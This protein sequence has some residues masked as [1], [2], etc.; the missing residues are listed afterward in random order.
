MNINK[1]Y[2]EN[3]QLNVDVRHLQQENHRF[4]KI[5]RNKQRVIDRQRDYINEILY[6]VRNALQLNIEALRY[7]STEPRRPSTPGE[8]YE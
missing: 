3:H 5:I 1:L 2:E 6:Y 8:I 4:K 7:S